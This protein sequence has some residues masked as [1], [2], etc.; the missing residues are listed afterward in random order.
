MKSI[1]TNN[2]IFNVT[3]SLYESIKNNNPEIIKEDAWDYYGS[4]NEL[5]IYVIKDLIDDIF[6]GEKNI[7]TSDIRKKAEKIYKDAQN[8]SV[9]PLN[10]FDSVKDYLGMIKK[11]HDEYKKIK[12]KKNVTYDEE[13]IVQTSKD[14]NDYIDNY[15][16]EESPI[17]EKYIKRILLNT[18][19]EKYVDTAVDR[20]MKKF[21]SSYTDIENISDEESIKRQ[22]EDMKSLYNNVLN[23]CKKLQNLIKD[24][25]KKINESVI[26]ESEDFNDEKYDA[27]YKVFAENGIDIVNKFKDELL[28][29]MNIT[30]SGEL[31]TEK[32]DD[33]ELMS[34]VE[35]LQKMYITSDTINYIVKLY[36]EYAKNP[37]LSDDIKVKILQNI[38]NVIS[39]SYRFLQSFEK[40][41]HTSEEE[42]RQK[43][44]FAYAVR[45]A[46]LGLSNDEKF[47]NINDFNKEE[48]KKWYF[49]TGLT[50]DDKNLLRYL[51]PSEWNAF[52]QTLDYPSGSTEK[53]KRENSDKIAKRITYVVSKATFDS[54]IPDNVNNFISKNLI[55][56]ISQRLLMKTYKIYNFGEKRMNIFDSEIKKNYIDITKNDG[57]LYKN[58]IRVF[59]VYRGIPEEK[60]WNNV[61]VIH[62]FSEKSF[63]VIGS[64]IGQMNRRNE[65][66]IN[67]SILTTG[68]NTRSRL[69]IITPLNDKG[70]MEN[71]NG[72]PLFSD[73]DEITNNDIKL[74]NTIKRRYFILVTEGY[75]KVGGTLNKV[76]NKIKKSVSNNNKSLFGFDTSDVHYN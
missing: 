43:N 75:F 16:G 64:T 10:A 39:D 68:L 26:N 46:I 44:K 51:T 66:I 37:K 58:D 2:G 59:D 30:S 17:I 22:K 42:N 19:P 6:K 62:C 55:D 45:R 48:F 76:Y 3:N 54:K 60:F 47:N 27:L 5:D 20:Y 40:E 74:I 11:Q 57:F 32:T 73:K 13:K 38:Y 18:I 41:N 71:R 67:S 23:D 4:G 29:G 8:K 21:H 70:K 1:R 49:N 14:F 61:T 33:N 56:T 35:D 50:T 69:Y 65:L 9:D 28:N 31:T 12:Q 72:Q 15:N 24:N 25:E 53:T 63:D 36:D 7:N 34:R 52:L